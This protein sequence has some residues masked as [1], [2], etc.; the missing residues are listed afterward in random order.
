MLHI[1]ADTY[2]HQVNI[3]QVLRIS[4]LDFSVV[5]CVSS[6]FLSVTK[7]KKNLHRVKL[8]LYRVTQRFLSEAASLKQCIDC[9]FFAPE[10]DI[11]VKRFIRSSLFKDI[12]PE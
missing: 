7:E 4:Y 8:R 3:I 11:Q 2:K 5:L 9:W 1:V 6:V 12:H 10:S